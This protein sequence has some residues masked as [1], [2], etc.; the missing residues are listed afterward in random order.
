MEKSWTHFTYIENE[1]DDESHDGEINGKHFARTGSS[2]T[3]LHYSYH[4][5]MAKA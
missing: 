5:Y 4:S 2:S 1:A 3:E